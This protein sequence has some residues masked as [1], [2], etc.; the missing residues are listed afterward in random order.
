MAGS[1]H[2]AALII[3]PKQNSGKPCVDLPPNHGNVTPERKLKGLVTP[4]TSGF[5]S[6]KSDAATRR[7]CDRVA[8]VYVQP[9]RVKI[10]APSCCGY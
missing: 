9:A 10:V 3:D 8:A 4:S 6:P 2:R 1:A 5:A 7:Y